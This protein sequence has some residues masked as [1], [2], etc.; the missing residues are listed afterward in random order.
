MQTNQEHFTGKLGIRDKT[1][2][3]IESL[4]YSL[5]FELAQSRATGI[6]EQYDDLLGHSIANPTGAYVVV[7]DKPISRLRRAL[8]L[9][10]QD[11][12]L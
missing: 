1:K 11:F 9:Y 3:Q 2:N 8:V 4:I 6:R 7:D 10:E 12:E 5:V